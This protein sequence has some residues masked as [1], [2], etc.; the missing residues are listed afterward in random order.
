M[1][2]F[3]NILT[4]HPLLDIFSSSVLVSLISL[5]FSFGSLC[6]AFVLGFR[7][8]KKIHY[9]RNSLLKENCQILIAELI[10]DDKLSPE[11]EKMEVYFLKN[12]HRKQIFLEELMSLHKSFQGDIATTIEQYYV[13]NGYD[14]ISINKLKSEKMHKILQGVDELVEMKNYDSIQILE[15]LLHQTID[16]GLKNYLITAIIKLDPENGLRKLFSF[17]NFLTDWLQL[18]IIKI[19]DEKKF[20]NPPPL[21]E[22]IEKGNSFAIFGCRLSAYTKSEKD[23]PLLK[24]LIYTNDIPLKIEVIKTLGI[25]DAQEVNE[26]LIKTYFNQKSAVK[27]AILSTLVKFKKT[28]NFPFFVSCSKSGTHQTQL[29]AL[30]GINLLLE[31]GMLSPDIYDTKTLN[32]NKLNKINATK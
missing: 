29:L 27:A 11:S 30:Q 26:L 8:L 6:L 21:E 15:T 32:F 16:Y 19:L 28:S 18:R 5:F 2:I 23:I 9:T 7:K 22:W 24:S 13:L 25:V 4:I 3:H 20:F 12:S 10:F 31:E 1:I 17:D 14:K